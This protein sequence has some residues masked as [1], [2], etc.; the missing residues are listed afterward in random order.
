MKPVEVSKQIQAGVEEVFAIFADLEN[1]AERITEIIK[2]DMLTE[3]PVGLGTRWR[4]T[5]MM[6]KREATEEME[7][8]AFDPPNG[9]TVEAESHGSHYRTELR[10]VPHG[11]G[12]KATMTFY[13]QP[14]TLM[15]KIMGVLTAPM[16]RGTLEKCLH[17]DMDDLKRYLESAQA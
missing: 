9:Y 12:T 16:M 10:F 1:A 6:F 13:A 7:I 4:E 2:L 17:K 15:A 3:G 14:L 11:E 8:T 5:R